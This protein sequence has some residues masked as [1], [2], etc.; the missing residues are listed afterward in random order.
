MRVLLTTA[1]DGSFLHPM[2][3]LGW[4]L[5]TAGHEVLVA[6]QV[7][8]NGHVTGAGL[9]AV[10]V[11]RQTSSDRLLAAMRVTPE[12]LEQAR[13]GLHPP[14]DVVG[15]DR[16]V[17]WEEMV[18]AY[19]EDVDRSRY[20]NFPMIG[21]LVALAR[22]WRPDLV[23]WEPFT[24][25][26]AIAA[27]ACGAA[28][29]RML[30]GADVHGV[31]RERFLRM[32][33][34]RP[35]ER[36]EDPLADWLGSYARKYGADFTEDMTC[37][38]LTLDQFPPSLQIEADGLEYLHA[39]HVA[40]GG[41]AVVPDW[42]RRPPARPRVAVTTGFTAT[43]FFGGLPFDLR[44]VLLELSRLDVEVVATASAADRD[45]LRGLPGNVRLESWVPL[46]VLASTC[47]AAVTH[48]GAGTLS[49]FVAHGV[50][51]LA[52]P[53]HFDEPVLGRALAAAG[54]ALC[55][56]PR[57]ADGR[58]VRDGVARL[59]A[60]PGLRAG[61]AALRAESHALP[62]LNQLVTTLEDRVAS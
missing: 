45:A 5:R 39:R 51:Q 52:L 10:P 4:A 50:P 7:F 16:D 24:P 3:G 31:T 41:A 23:V 62:T 22:R 37:G 25:A 21:G 15:S 34:A 53:F 30:F 2:V 58:A 29:A 28:H 42:L 18:A 54:G 38:Q 57:E 6:D 36:R 49:A 14:Y 20:E 9:T 60:D 11:G 35:A 19:R 59:L 40:Y 47:S 26:G 8:A 33:D 1:N 13:P 48:A 27:K 43:G 44:D 17:T 32:R 46:E 56:D 61:A 12:M 55:L